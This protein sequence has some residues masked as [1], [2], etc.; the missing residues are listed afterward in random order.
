MKSITKLLLSTLF[1]CG[2]SDSY[3]SPYANWKPSSN[4][5]FHNT[6][7]HLKEEPSQQFVK[8]ALLL[9]TSNSMDGLI[10][11]A[12]AQLWDIVNEF[13]YARCGNHSRP[14]LQIAL[15]EY[16]NDNLSSKEG[17][18]RQVLNFSTD[19]D[20]ISEKLFSLSTNGGE[21]YC[22]T[23]INTSLKQ[24]DWGKNPDDLKLIF[25]A[26]N[27][28]FT[29]GKL[30]YRDATA[31]AKE[32]DVVVNTIFCGNYEQG[33]ST[34]WKDGAL[35]TGGDYIAIDHNQEIV[36]IATPY[37]DD[38]L[39]LNKKLNGTYVAYGSLGASKIVAQEVQDS[40]AQGLQE[41]TAIKR[42]VS[43]SSRLYK[44]ST[45][46]LVDALEEEVIEVDDIEETAL[47]SELKGKTKAQIESYV[48]AK[49]TERSKIQ[50]EIQQLNAKREG[51]ILKQKKN[52]Q[53]EL[54]NAMVKA[55]KKQ[56]SKKNYT[57]E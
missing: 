53:G 36:H 18:I 20:E 42:A 7:S 4:L 24:L 10:N 22:G 49:K 48:A 15:Y 28:P 51:Y 52:Q 8:I 57:W 25:I 29:Q 39:R 13:T 41:N 21:E 31:Q 45:W 33:I 40:N 16:G 37:D 34:K 19:L 54:E 12:K 9:D 26:G 11:Q 30:S 32:K 14:G 56:A 55:I 5:D 17:Y 6:W 44:N 3:G 50:K 46:D 27:E 23:V 47:P 1:I 2:I 43:K 38:I 35:L